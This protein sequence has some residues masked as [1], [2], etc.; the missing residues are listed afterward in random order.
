MALAGGHPPKQYCALQYS[1]LPYGGAALHA[2]SAVVYGTS[3]PL[4]SRPAAFTPP[5]PIADCST[6]AVAT[7][8][9][10]YTAFGSTVNSPISTSMVLEHT[11]AAFT[12]PYADTSQSP[13]PFGAPSA[14]AHMVASS[15]LA[16]HFITFASGSAR[17]CMAVTLSSVSTAF[18][19]A[20]PRSSH[21]LVETTRRSRHL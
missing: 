14:I 19:S 18:M 12:P 16:R 8:P 9:D 7:E 10:V 13:T 5:W 4:I 2:F 21:T 6:P 17:T 11:V 1:G 3:V 15:G 20:H